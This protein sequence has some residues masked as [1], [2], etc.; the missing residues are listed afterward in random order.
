M[1]INTQAL[2]ETHYEVLINML[3]FSFQIRFWIYQYIFNIKEP[4]IA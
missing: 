4:T 2:R 1:Q 3:Y